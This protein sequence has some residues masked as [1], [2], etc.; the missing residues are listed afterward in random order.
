MP[1]SC[2]AEGKLEKDHSFHSLKVSS[3]VSTNSVVLAG[4]DS[5]TKPGPAAPGQTRY[6]LD[7]KSLRPSRHARRHSEGFSQT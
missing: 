1:S 6:Y 5:E 4:G 3:N 7:T 2:L